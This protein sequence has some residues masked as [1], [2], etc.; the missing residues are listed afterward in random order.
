MG[1]VNFFAVIS[2]AL[3]VILWNQ[4]NTDGKT[5]LTKKH[6]KIKYE[7]LFLIILGAAFIVR[8][9][10]AVSYFGYESDM[11]CFIGWADR[12]SK[13]G[14]H[15][16]YSKEVFTDYPPG[17][18][19]VLAV[20]GKIRDA[21]QLEYYSKIYLVLIKLPA[22][23]CDMVAGY[24]LFHVT[25]ER[26]NG[27]SSLIIASF[28]LFN[29]A[30]I[31][32]SSIWGQVDSVFTL[33]VILMGYFIYKEKLPYA[34]FAYG[35][36]ILIKPQVVIFTPVLI[37]AIIDQVFLRKFLLKKFIINLM[38]GICAILVVL[39]LASLFGLSQ[40]IH[41]YT[42]TISSYPYASTN[43]Y[44]IW[45]MLGLNWASQ[46]GK[47]LMFTY[48]Q[49]GTIFILLI[50]GVATY[51]SFKLKEN[52]SKYFYISAFIIIGLFTLS[53]R[54]H[55]RY[56]FPALS[57]LLFA[58]CLRPRKRILLMYLALSMIHLYNVSHVLLKYDVNNFNSKAMIPMFIGFLM[59]I[60]FVIMV[61][62]SLFIYQLDK[63]SY[64]EVNES[65]DA[66]YGNT[67]SG[68]KFGVF[69]KW[70]FKE[71]DKEAI[72]IQISKKKVKITRIDFIIFS[73]IT[74]IYALIA[75]HDL[76]YRKAPETSWE[77][78]KVGDSIILDLGEVKDVKSIDYYLGNYENRIFDV[79]ISDRLDGNFTSLG[80]F[81][82]EAVFR[83]GTH[84]VNTKARYIKL[85][86]QSGN[87]SLKELVLLG[88]DG[89]KIVPTNRKDSAVQ[90]LFDEQ[91]LYPKR[92][93]FRD[94]TYFDEIYHART[95]YE[96]LHGLYSYE[97]THPP[98]GKIFIAIGMVMF[99]VNPFGWRVM[100]TLFGVAMVPLIFIFAKKLMKETWISTV[101]CILFTFDFMHFS[102]TRIATIDVFVTFF[103]ILMYY[104]MYQYLNLSFY[105]TKLS[106]TFIPLGLCGISM[107]FGMACKWTGV[108]AAAGLAILFFISV[109][110]RYQEYQFA[111]KNR[112]G[113]TEGILHEDIITKF[114]PKL[115]K[116]ILFC[117]LVFI[118]IPFTIYLLSY[119]PFRDGSN[120][121]LFA[122]M[123]H[124][125]FSMYN[126]HSHVDATHPYSSW[127][128]Q[129]P[130]IYRPIWYYSGHISNTV[131]E[132]ISAFGNPFVWWIGIPSFLYMIYLYLH[133]KDRW[134]LVLCISYLAQYVPWFLV[135][136][137]T[138]IYHYFP[139][140][141]FVTLMIGYS[142]KNIVDQ[143]PK[144]KKVAYI[145]C[146]L[147]IILFI[148]F[149]PVLSGQAIS[150]SYVSTFLRW[151]NTWVLVS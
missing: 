89:K 128:Y 81:T 56:V 41:Q 70:I 101:V 47:F 136:R 148:M 111:L 95:A 13:V 149:Y 36:G 147:V 86:S 62:Y 141:P 117:I 58:Y 67:I 77:T 80:S 33:A 112:E 10:G 64:T 68:G 38:S 57:L 49:W 4:I 121:G 2:V 50:I 34:Y 151:F 114:Y 107:G 17:Y 7:M 150:K 16:F 18:M 28:Y 127:W 55:E 85:I 82:M 30:V 15:N 145:Y 134:A 99:G 71:S 132:G 118:I 20:L 39:G 142:I 83:W 87:M 126:Y 94:S 143:R 131:S 104:F 123:I 14:F 105:D 48:Q 138:F 61:Y 66:Q 52:K 44:N 23:L 93:T 91:N 96:Y 129:W 103:I 92:S 32:N 6:I 146:A 53:V 97:N 88:N 133:K 22:I 29:P 124:N 5:D 40:V 45:T 12:L 1:Y 135:T 25:K 122:R 63:D 54:M 109:I 130:I 37:F 98:L 125:Q 100:G 108:Y 72:P 65:S 119:I 43:A 11:N 26:F 31:I 137:I 73:V 19:L 8:I 59:L 3:S 74:V 120:N 113:N 115:F 76:G 24:M 139:S 9:I 78:S 144:L 75:F 79:R 60:F 140:V 90:K 110:R 51:L 69:S 102:Q 46:S 21:L 42:D 116:T 27:K 84:D 35:I 106:K